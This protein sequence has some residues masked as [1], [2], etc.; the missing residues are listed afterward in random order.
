[1]K[2]L[3]VGVIGAGMMGRQHVEAA[4]RIP[5]VEVVA[6]ADANA[7]LAARTCE[8]LCTPAALP[9]TGD[10]GRGGA[11]RGAQRTPNNLHFEI[12]REL[13]RRGVNVY[14]EKPLANTSAE[15]A[16]LCALAEAAGV[17]AGVN[18][19]YRQNAMVRE[20]HERA[21]PGGRRPG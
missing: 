19:N 7:A 11:G 13:L 8:E 3:R 15:T 12:N 17:K 4:R 9:T 20:M 2:T 16:E 10:A 18:F 6:L 21:H 14:C 1:M 5:G